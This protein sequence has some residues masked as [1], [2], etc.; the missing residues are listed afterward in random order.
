MPQM[1]VPNIPGLAKYISEFDAK[2]HLLSAKQWCHGDC[3]LKVV[4]QP[5][6]SGTQ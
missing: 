5:A 3:H 6:A 2:L 1:Y 4:H